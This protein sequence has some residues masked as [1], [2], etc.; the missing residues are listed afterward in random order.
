MDQEPKRQLSEASLRPTHSRVQRTQPSPER[1]YV[2]AQDGNKRKRPWP[3]RLWN[4]FKDIAILFSLAVNVILVAVIVILVLNAD[5]LFELKNSLAEPWLTDLDQAFAALG[6][7]TIDS[8]VHINDTIPVVFDL[9]LEQDTDVILTAPVPLSVPAQFVL[10]GGGGA[11]NGTVS[12]NLPQG[13]ALP[14]ELGMSVPV[15]TTVPV[16]MQVPVKMELSECG[17][18][19]A[20]EQLRAVFRPIAG[21]VQ[22]LPD[23]PEELLKRNE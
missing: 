15:S 8:T 3:I 23:S 7:T 5:V 17:M 16:V 4:A 2:V 22:S 21:F 6:A 13:Q 9:A 18:A 11:I 19:P 14:V 20:V 10:P 12:L 1:A